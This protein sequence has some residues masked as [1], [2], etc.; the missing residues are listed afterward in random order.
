MLIL[1]L[2]NIGLYILFLVLPKID[3]S[4]K[5]FTLI[6]EKFRVIRVIIHAF[7]AAIFFVISFYSLGYK[8]NTSMVL[9]YLV[10]VFF[11]LLGNYMGNIRHN[12]FIGIR[13]PW[14][15][16]SEAVWT[17]THRLT[18]RLW[19]GATLFTMLILWAVPYPQFFFMGYVAAITIVPVAY[20]FILYK[21][22]PA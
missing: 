6:T 9:F 13:T 14:T 3:P 7:L 16:A 1:P 12:Y 10:L 15:L 8:F 11:L 17:K 2:I 18:A 4:G 19:V 22:Q 21:K 20:S 5:N